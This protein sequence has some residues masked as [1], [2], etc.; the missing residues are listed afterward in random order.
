[1]RKYMMFFMLALLLELSLFNYKYYLTMQNEEY[2][3]EL[4]M[5]DGLMSTGK[6]E[7]LVT[8]EGDCTIM[9]TGIRSKVRALRFDIGYVVPDVSLSREAQ[10]IVD[11]YEKQ[12]IFV[13]I[14]AQDGA[15]ELGMTL[16]RRDIV[17]EAE[18]TTYM[19]PHLSG[20][21]GW[22]QYHLTVQPG[23]TVRLYK[24]TVNPQIPFHFSLIRVLA[25]GGMLSLVC[26]LRP[27]SPA[28]TAVYQRNPVQGLIICGCIL[29][30]ILLFSRLV[31]MNPYF[32]YP[33]WS[34]HNQYYE[35]A[36]AFHERQLYLTKEV[37]D[38]LKEMDNPYDTALRSAMAAEAGESVLWDHAY[39]NGH[40]YVYFGVVPELLF[41]YP[42]Y[43]LFGEVDENGE[44][45]GGRL[46]HFKI[47]FLC[48]AAEVIAV[49]LLLGE[50][51]RLWYRRTPF[52]LYLLLAMG[53]SM[54]CGVLTIL[55]RPDFYSVPIICGLVFSLFG[56]YFW[57]SA[58]QEHL[59]S[60]RL[61]AGSLCM[62]LVAGCRPQMVVMSF[63]AVP[64][65]WE[66]IK[67]KRL[68][69]GKNWAGTLCF[70]LPYILVAAELMYYNAARFGSPFDFGAN[71]NLTTNDMTGRGWEPGR[72]GLGLFTYLFQPVNLEAGF[73]FIIQNSFA[74]SYLGTTIRESTYGGVFAANLILLPLLFLPWCKKY[75]KNIAGY[76]LSVISLA[77]AVLVVTAD[78]Q[79][80]GILPRYYSDFTWMMYFAVCPLLLSLYEY[81]LDCGE[82]LPMRLYRYFLTA[83]CVTG[84][85]YHVLRIY[86]GGTSALVLGN[87]SAFYKAAYTIAFWR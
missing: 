38:F 53:F 36:E 77:C 28:Y 70:A 24:I 32:I 30:E 27:G 37:P 73:P 63:L 1:M 80:A 69:A 68:L 81:C 10:E 25:V 58:R 2:V 3:P 59:I 16:G 48:A 15:N 34:H 65:F 86:A 23:E 50:I 33:V 83:A 60:W 62:A 13:R 8:E 46:E 21:T 19:I 67:R 79:M 43:E 39:Y 20:E 14:E 84:I 56:L 41:Y 75:Y 82:K 12:K 44:F 31:M 52:V 5:G 7:Y 26:L 49:Y 22:I 6:G 17:H 55:L 40:Y 42:Y 61:S 51:I 87:P 71:Y 64:L 35:L 4:V 85:T 9:L 45:Q 66:D 18:K 11:A 54:G 29:A 74:S 47:I 76:R 72:I 57:L 78:T